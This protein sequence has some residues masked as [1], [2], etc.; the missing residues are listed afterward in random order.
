MLC[1]YHRRI[2]AR[3]VVAEQR[4]DGFKQ[5][6]RFEDHAGP[7]AEGNVVHRTVLIVGVV[8]Q[9][10]QVDLHPHAYLGKVQGCSSWLTRS[11][12]HPGQR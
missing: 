12:S 11:V 1:P 8:P 10:V 7:S 3:F 2:R 9:V 4:F 5:R 6:F